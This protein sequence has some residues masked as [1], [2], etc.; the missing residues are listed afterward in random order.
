MSLHTHTRTMTN[1]RVGIDLASLQL[2]QSPNGSFQLAYSFVDF[3]S[4]MVM[5]TK[6]TICTR[7]L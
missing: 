7:K 3:V 5:F 4:Y 6:Y 1:A 2:H